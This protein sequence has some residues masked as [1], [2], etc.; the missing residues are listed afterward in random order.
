MLYWAGYFLVGLGITYVLGWSKISLP[1]REA[2][3]RSKFAPIRLLVTLLEC[4]ACTS[5][6]VGVAAYYLMGIRA[7]FG[8]GPIALGLFTLAGNLLLAQQAGMK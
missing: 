7:P 6:W 3:G 5:F 2:A 4:P 8:S 1:F